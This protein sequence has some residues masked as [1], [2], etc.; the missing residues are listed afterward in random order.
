MTKRRIAKE[1]RRF[2]TDQER[3]VLRARYPHEKTERIARDLGRPLP[4]VFAMA[5]QLGL[6]KTPEYLETPDACRLRR[7]GNVGAEHRFQKGH[8]PWSKGKHYVAGGRS[9]ETRFKKGQHP[10]TWKPLGSTRIAD[11]YL[12]RKVTD[13][14]YPPRDWV[15]VHR[16]VWIAANG[17]IP[18]GYAVAFLAGRATTVEAEITLDALELVSRRDLMKRN[19]VHNLPKELAQVVQLRGALN[20]QINQRSRDGEQHQ[21]AA[22]RAVRDAARTARS[23]QADGHRPRKSRL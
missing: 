13:T 10:H 11:G 19:T 1:P 2:W 17:P 18:P 14:G 20:R 15:A 22:R 6:K 8:V 16:L 5:A 23:G 3:E 9:A 4:A 7:G 12:Q 21:G